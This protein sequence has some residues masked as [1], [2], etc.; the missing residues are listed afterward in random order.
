MGPNFMHCEGRGGGLCTDKNWDNEGLL[1]KEKKKV[2]K[3]E[4]GRLIRL[5]ADF[6]CGRK[7]VDL[8]ITTTPRA[9]GKQLNETHAYVH[10]H[11]Y[12]IYPSCSRS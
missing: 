6:V 5:F 7:I 8:S 3:F 9:T 1:G 4:D 12:H 10:L 2:G 11:T